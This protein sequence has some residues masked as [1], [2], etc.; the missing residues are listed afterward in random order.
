MAQ[1]ELDDFRSSR[2]RHEGS[3][4]EVAALYR[5][6]SLGLPEVDEGAVLAEIL[7]ITGDI[8]ACEEALLCLYEKETDQMVVHSSTRDDT[9][10]VSM[11]EPSVLRRVFETGRGE[12]VNDL[13]SDLD[14]NP[15][16]AHALDARQVIAAP[17]V[18]AR[19]KL[20]VLLAVN[21][22]SGAFTDD[23]LRLLT[24]LAE[25]SASAVENIELKATLERQSQEIEGLHRLSR[26]RPR[27]RAWTELSKSRCGSSAISWTAARWLC[28]FMTKRPMP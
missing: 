13:L 21:S 12:L 19:D 11:A 1:I 23:D 6:A 16:L 17:L 20:G 25:R 15:S 7:R 3:S 8:V 27:L 22:T 5:I 18:V 10:R 2:Q 4:R 24:L 26:L 9:T 28:S 14:S